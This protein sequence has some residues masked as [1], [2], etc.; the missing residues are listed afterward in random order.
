MT[1]QV[2]SS[3][4][5]KNAPRIENPRKGL[6]DSVMDGGSNIIGTEKLLTIIQMKLLKRTEGFI[7]K[8]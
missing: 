4:S 1:G 3:Y 2:G 8:Y 5:G 6:Y 7:K